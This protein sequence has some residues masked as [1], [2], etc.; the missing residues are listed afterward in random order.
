MSDQF[1]RD[2]IDDLFHDSLHNAERKPPFPVWEKI[3]AGLDKDRRRRLVSWWSSGMVAILIFLSLAGFWLWPAKDHRPGPDRPRLSS[4]AAPPA[5]IVHQQKPTHLLIPAR[6]TDATVGRNA[7][8]F[9]LSTPFGRQ[10][11]V[12]FSA[13]L[14]ASEPDRKFTDLPL[15][16]TLTGQK[17]PFP[18]HIIAGKALPPVQLLATSQRRRPKFAITAYLSQELAGYSLADHDSTGPHGKEIEKRENSSFSTSLGI[19]ASYSI[20]RHW[21]I[22]SGLSLSRSVSVSNPGKAAAVKDMNGNV[23]YQVYTV[24]GYGYVSPSGV[25]NIG[26]SAMTGKVTGKLD[27]VS[28][29]LALSRTWV[30][31]RFSFLAGAGFS[32]NFLTRAT[33]Q[34][35]LSSPAGDDQAREVAQYGLRKV[36]FGVLLKGECQYQFANNYGVV[37]LASFKSSVGPVNAHTSYNTYPY[38]LGL[39]IGVTRAF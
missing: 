12:V 38:N 15:T 17:L 14:A 7:R 27:Y 23:S 8:S 31:S 29:P 35:S 24:T 33:V 18:P 5:A 20:S 32:T 11:S 34:A 19:L 3:E 30:I 26:D 4:S 25:A 22:E 10:E 16:A 39:G 2:D 36:T 13:S 6:R 21:T 37:V 28:I 1:K 9:Q